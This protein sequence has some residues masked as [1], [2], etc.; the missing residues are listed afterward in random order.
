M[1]G[2]QSKGQISNLEMTE[3]IK[4]EEGEGEGEEG[5]RKWN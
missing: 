1:A 2:W 4:E 3:D 5:S